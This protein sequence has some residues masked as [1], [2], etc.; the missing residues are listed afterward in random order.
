MYAN[1]YKDLSSCSETTKSDVSNLR[2]GLTG[3]TSNLFNA[4]SD[5]D[6]ISE[7]G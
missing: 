2:A 4:K 5:I 6:K 7:V 1:N 3:L